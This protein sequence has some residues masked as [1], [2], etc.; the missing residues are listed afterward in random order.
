M[1]TKKLIDFLK[2]ALIYM[3]TISMLTAAGL[4]INARQIAGQSEEIPR[5]KMRIF[6]IGGMALSEINENHVTPIQITIT[7]GGNAFTAIYSDRSVLDI[8][9]YGIKDSIRDI[10]GKNSKCRILDKKEGEELWGKCAALDKSVYVKYAGDYIYPFIYTFLDKEWDIKNSADD[11]SNELAMVHELFIID[12][13]ELLGVTK[14]TY[15]RIALFTPAPVSRHLTEANLSAYKNIA[16][17]VPCDFL[18][19]EDISERRGVNENNIENLKFSESFHLFQSYDKYSFV[20]EFSNPLLD[21]DNQINTDHA[22]IKNL[23]KILNFN[24]ENSA[25]Y[26]DG[27]GITFRDSKNTVRFYN[28]GQI[29][30]NHKPSDSNQNGGGIHLAKFLSYDDN[31]YTYYEKIKAASVFVS[32]LDRELA[33]NECSLY[34]KS[35]TINSK[36]DMNVIFSYYYEGIEIKINGSNEAIVL[37]INENSF[38]QIKINSIDISLSGQNMVKNRNPIFDLSLIDREISKELQEASEKSEKGE[39]AKKY[40]L[41]YDETSDKFV[42]GDFR[43]VYNID[44]KN[45]TAKAVWELK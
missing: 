23:F 1:K 31:Y 6:E 13:G 9:E 4:Y 5:E 29:I 32:S 39:I 12:D 24:I 8:Y 37:T 44:Y 11:F 22:Y 33:G 15:G 30:Y 16:G 18:K 14:D 42:V 21:P 41:N 43:L 2:T 3:L 40:N 25:S 10:F 34:L 36:G 28:D 26:S 38:T 35:V 19:G 45:N 7:V 27:E 20:L 17:M